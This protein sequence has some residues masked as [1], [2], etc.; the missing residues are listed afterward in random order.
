MSFGQNRPNLH[1]RQKSAKP[2]ISW[3]NPEYMLNNSSSCS[4][5]HIWNIFCIKTKMFYAFKIC[6]I[7][8]NSG[9]LEWM[10]DLYDA[11]LKGD[12]PRTIPAK[13]GS[14]V[15]WFW[16][17]RL[18]C[19]L[20]TDNDGRWRMPSDGKSSHCLWQ[21]ELKTIHFFC[22]VH[23]KYT[24]IWFFEIALNMT[25]KVALPSF[26]LQVHIQCKFWYNLIVEYW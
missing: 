9:H 25:Q 15:Q 8:S 4:Y 3:R 24:R 23:T 7:F 22:F 12:H 13:F 16:K 5:I 17:R 26:T 20:F 19:E 1:I 10:A 11:I 14:L 18:K 21:G 2:Y 6:S